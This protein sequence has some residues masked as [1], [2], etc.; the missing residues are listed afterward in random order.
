MF[1]CYVL[2]PI[3]RCFSSLL[4]VRLM[5]ALGGN[6]T[7]AADSIL[8][9]GDSEI[10]HF[11]MLFVTSYVNLNKNFPA[12]SVVCVPPKMLRP[13]SSLLCLPRGNQFC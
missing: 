5:C 1:G 7:R 2:S 4:D 6:L 13:S 11:E 10:R 3:F 8:R 12:G 9:T